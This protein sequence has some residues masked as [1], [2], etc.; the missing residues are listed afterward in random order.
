MSKSNI[1]ISGCGITYHSKKHKTWTVI[2][3]SLGANIIDVSAPAVSNQWILNKSFLQLKNNGSIDVVVIQLTNLG[4][5]DVW[6]DQ[7]RIDE[8]VKNDTSRNFI[9]QPDF[10]II[11]F[12]DIKDMDFLPD[13]I[14]PSSASLEHFSKKN[15]QKF[16]YS[17]YLEIE[18]IFCKLLLLDDY[19]QKRN[20]KLLVFQGYD[21]PWRPEHVEPMSSIIKNLGQSLYTEYRK[22]PR[23]DHHDHSNRNSVPCFQYQIDIAEKIARYIDDPDLAEKITL[24]QKKFNG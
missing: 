10:S 2:F 13:S 15:W 11:C 7:A 20:I 4:K 18:D 6:V 24:L 12:D 23:Y 14:W 16:L 17:P 9:V 22:S 5:L 19:C 1:L 21:L 8:L 3:K